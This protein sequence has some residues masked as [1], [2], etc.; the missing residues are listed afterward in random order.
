MK[1]NSLKKL[2][3]P[4]LYSFNSIITKVNKEFINFTGFTMD[5]LLGKSLIEIGA[6]IRINSQILLGNISGKY[7]GYV[8]TK[9]LSPREV[10]IS[11]FNGKKS[12]VSV[13]TF[14]EKRNPRLEDKLIFVEQAFIDN[15]ADV[16]IYSVP[17]LTLLKANQKYLD[18]M[19]SPFN[20]EQNSIGMS[21]RKIVTGFEGSKCEVIWNTVVETQKTSYVK[22]FETDPFERGTTYWDSYL[23]PIFENK[24]MKYIFETSTDVT[25]RV[26]KNQSIER[27]NKIIQQQ[28][29][30]EVV[31]ENITD[32]ISIFDEKGQYILSNKS[33]KD[34]YLPSYGYMEN[35]GDEYE[36]SE[37]YD[38]D[39]KKIDLENIPSFR[40]MRGEKFKSMRM[41][42]KFSTKT[43]QI[44][45]SG[46]PIYNSDGNF[47]LGVL[48]SRD[49]TDYFKH[50]ET[51]RSQHEFMNRIIDTFDL[52]VVRLSCPDLKIVDINQKAF[53]ITKLL[54]PDIISISKLK[55]SKLEDL[56]KAYKPFDIS[57]YYQ[58]INEVIKEK[59]NK[60]LNKRSYMINGNQVYWNIIFEPIIEVNG[61][62]GEILIV[63][64]DITD[65]IKANI[66]ME[67]ALKS[68]EEIFANISHELKTP[69]NVIS[70]TVQLFNMY[71]NDG[72]LDKRK[73][74][75]TKY[76]GSM[77][78]NC[79]RLS[80]LIDN[81]V[82]ISKIKAGFFQL[83]LSNNNIVEVVEEIVMS[84]SKFT[85]SKVL[86]IVF[87]TDIEE[88]VIAC[89]SE[90]IERVMLNLISNAIKFSNDGDEIFVNIKDKNEFVEISVRDNG[91]G[92]E[93]KDF[94][95]IFDR[96]MQVDKSISRN[97]EGAGIGL[98]LT[99]SIIELHG[100]TIFV[101]SEVGKGSKFTFIL[102]SK[103]IIKESLLSNS[104]LENKKVRIQLEFS[105]IYP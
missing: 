16:A 26:L 19:D 75:I 66:V 69:V 97:A 48:C 5:E 35:I 1:Y 99:K 101:Q 58:Y 47:A 14:V 21:I 28:K 83:N 7:S 50:E 61:E 27:Q 86:N 11:L 45:V 88:K 78:Q 20:K 98:N 56:L 30:L 94:S 40:V 13:Y 65:E 90:K 51:L 80:K 74:S 33:T 53:Y 3:L 2:T 36:Q 71:Y 102:P 23:T 87:D 6:M 24:K 60:Y 34:M 29:E 100:G 18:F 89:D 42:V 15:I 67:K 54:R 95:M 105:D 37:L 81:I 85:E 31:I 77:K 43:L 84:V 44:D 96:F 92:I 22:E 76:I 12:N 93:E 4:C 9:S 103:K 10:D 79:F 59:K 72:S 70:S 25:E 55:D 91:I 49:M 57:K 46:T 32:G 39:G 8:F 62:I 17:D 52:P 104:N 38:I 82:D 73:E 63:I 41:A 64:M 68:Q